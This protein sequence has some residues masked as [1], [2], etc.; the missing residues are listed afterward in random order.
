M[1]LRK[2]GNG[3]VHEFPEA[4]ET[5]ID[6]L[7]AED[8]ADEYGLELD[9]DDAA[10]DDEDREPEAAAPPDNHDSSAENPKS[11]SS[12]GTAWGNDRERF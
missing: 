5:E 2:G 11:Q 9:S 6:R 4:E 12:G 7:A 10:P 1:E 8:A 3:G